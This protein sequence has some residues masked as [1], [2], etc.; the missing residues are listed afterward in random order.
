M[1][2]FRWSVA[3]AAVVCVFVLLAVC[4][5]LL[6]PWRAVAQ[7][8][9][10]IS[11]TVTDPSGA[12]VPDA[13]VTAT[14]NATGVS[15][16]T[17]TSS[18][19]TYILT[20]LN[21]ATYS[22]KV[23]K[24]GFETAVLPQV[25]VYASQTATANATLTAGTVTQTVEV[26]VPAITLQTENADINTTINQELVKEVPILIGGG[27]GNE[28]PRDM[29]IDDFIF[30]SPGATG[31]EFEHRLDGGIGYQNE[32]MF[33]GVV[34]VQSETQGYQS[35]INPPF[36]LVNQINVISS[37][38]DAQYGL[39]QGV[40]SYRFASGT[41]TVHGDAFEALRNTMFNAAGADPTNSSYS[42][43]GN[44][45]DQ[46]LAFDK[47]SVPPL[48]QNSFGF[49]VGGPVWLPKIYDGKNKTFFYT[50]VDWFRQNA[51]GGGTLTVPTQSM[52]GGDF[53]ALC[54]TGFSGAGVCNDTQVNPNT[55]QTVVAHQ[56]YVPPN[57]TGA[58]VPAGCA[59]PPPGSPWPND[60]IPTGCFNAASASILGD[61]PQVSGNALSNN[62]PSQYGIAP[63]RQTNGGFTIDQ[64]IGQTQALHAAWWRDQYS[65]I[66]I[67]EGF[68]PSSPLIGG[69]I[70]PRLGT[71]LFLTYSKEFSS[72]LVMTAGFGWMGEL[73]FEYNLG[74]AVTNFPAVASG[75]VLPGIE[76]HQNSGDAF[77]P[78]TWGLVSSSGG[79]ETFSINRKLGLSFDNNFLWTH[80]RHTM[81]IGWEIR[82]SYQD[83]HECQQ[84]AGLFNFDAAETADP[85]F[86]NGE[87]GD[88]FAS[89][90]LGDVDSG[91]RRFVAEN[92]LRNLYGAP[93]IQDAIK[94]TPT[95]TLNA[96]IRWDIMR[97][98]LENDNNV[99]FF[100]PTEPNPGAVSTITGND[101]LGAATRLGFCSA[102][103]GYRRASVHW[104]DFSPRIGFAWQMNRKTVLLGGY[105][106]NYLDEGPYEYGNNKIS[107]DYGSLSNGLITYNSTGSNVPGYG[108]W[109]NGMSSTVQL[110]VPQA[111]PISPSEFD[112]DSVGLY[113]FSQDV[114]HDAY[115]QMW[116]FGVQRELSNNVMLSVS[117]VGNRALHLTSMLNPP[118]QTNPTYLSQFCP[119]GVPTDPTC[120]M[121]PASPNNAWTS[122]PSQA[123]LASLGF[124]QASVTCGS[125]TN[126]PGLAGTY[127]A[128]YVNFLCD[129]GPSRGFQQAVLPFPQLAPSESAG[130]A[131]DQFDMSGT[132]LYNAMQV[133]VQKRW[134][135]G[136]TFLVNY[137][138]SRDMSDTDSG[139][140]SFNFGALN[141]YDRAAEWTVATNDQTNAMNISGVYELPLGPGKRF[142]SHGGLLAK[143]LLG[144]WQISGVLAYASGFPINGTSGA[145]NQDGGEAF[146]SNTD[147]YL[148][149]FNRPNYN[150]SAPPEV[151]FGNYYK[152]LNL[153]GSTSAPVFNTG[154]FSDPGF[155]G[156]NSPRFISAYR[157]PWNYNENAAL[158]K[159]L[160]VGERVSV[161]LRMEYFNLLNR[162]YVCGPDTGVDDGTHFGLVNPGTFNVNGQNITVSQACQGNTPR[163]GE[164]Y[165]RLTF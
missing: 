90:L 148:N 51:L 52:V 16:S 89:F 32:V 165:L 156:G 4:V 87:T 114:G 61:I 95:F 98:F 50:S 159:H 99:T 36:E 54:A 125:S 157:M 66:G 56:L 20:D 147:P 112:G 14:N 85:T 79:G 23:E 122:A 104:H 121:S 65:T 158:A 151:N 2:S 49:S 163:Q 73:N 59:A 5:G 3:K 62:F 37:N 137:T 82:R 117:Y 118:N 146:T 96:G 161:E 18:A 19:G 140:S 9:S 130:G 75:T 45:P 160:Y 6:T 153:S 105:A 144:G 107:V 162:L 129:W 88:A 42:V 132:A 94:I 108:I 67:N 135:N 152:S 70:D 72:N 57:F 39:A 86:T 139:F 109:G 97:P 136:L 84:C 106:I 22:I 126:N 149:G 100:D 102:C 55:G 123:A 64:N 141:K 44:A 111:V 53:S 31:G 38:I 77:N 142:L 115:V 68:A 155:T 46:Q 8:L 164:A 116:N 101:L 145:G 35:N 113:E 110:G 21:P 47:A 41:N 83:D 12:V 80:G 92:R 138:L 43:V 7:G 78:S 91:F 33:N 10:G 133:Q 48:H 1:K 128:P 28:G 13:K 120:L 119:N 60:V 127:Y 29:Q 63:I 30:L 11:G 17:M 69:E 27:P 71:G 74:P 15:R 134:T 24:S 58:A 131:S 124:G 81:N 103:S 154:A 34:A 25:D 26:T 76:F 93:Y 143:N 150:P 40:A